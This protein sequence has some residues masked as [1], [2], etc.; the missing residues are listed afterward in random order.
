MR[1]RVHPF[2]DSHRDQISD[3]LNIVSNLVF[4][5]VDS[6]TWEIIQDEGLDEEQGAFSRADWQMAQLPIS[7]CDMEALRS[8]DDETIDRFNTF[9]ILLKEEFKGKIIDL[10]DYDSGVVTLVKTL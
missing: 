2:E 5:S 4:Q 3:L 1:E 8:F 7:D 10:I 6:K 9:D